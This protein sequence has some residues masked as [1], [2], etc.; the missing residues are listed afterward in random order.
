M[1]DETTRWLLLGASLAL[2]ILVWF[3]LIGLKE[4]NRPEGSYCCGG[5]DPVIG[6]IVGLWI[7]GNARCTTTKILGHNESLW[8]RWAFH[9]LR[10]R[11]VYSRRPI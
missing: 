8:K 10:F 7:N 5:V 2:T 1:S 6:P 3:R 11:S 4:H 9:R